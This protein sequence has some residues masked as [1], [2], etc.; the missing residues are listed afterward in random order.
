M[1]NKRQFRC[2]YI[3]ILI[4]KNSKADFWGL[5]CLILVLVLFVSSIYSCSD[6][7]L[8]DSGKTT[9]REILIKQNITAFEAESI[10]D[11][12][13]VQDTINKIL[14]TCGEN[15]QQFVNITIKND[16]VHMK[17][18]TKENWSRKY[19]KIKLELHTNQNLHIDIREPVH[20][21]TRGI[22]S[23]P[24]FV[25]WDWT[26]F[27]EIDVNLNV[28]YC[29]LINS[30]EHFGVIK[31]KGKSKSTFLWNRG[32]CKFLTD[33]LESASCY[34]IQHGW[35]DVYVNATELLTV[36]L[37]FTGNVYYFGQPA[38]INIQNQLS[39]GR[40]IKADQ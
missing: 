24:N 8:F 23:V 7:A 12:T 30:P 25:V 10:F 26:M 32:S 27:S 3:K 39:G 14:I 28:D 9:T 13:V 4:F 29:E 17:Q 33:S 38:Q 5:K 20:L 36:S 15:L 18:L 2:Q 11:I 16:T 6:N 22:F 34:V 37:E 19:E 35:G 31:A 40:L 21:V 1:N